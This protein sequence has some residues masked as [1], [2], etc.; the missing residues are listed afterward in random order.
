MGLI[1]PQSDCNLFSFTLQRGPQ[2]NGLEKNGVY[3]I[4]DVVNKLIKG[5]PSPSVHPHIRD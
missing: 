5:T 4:D 2:R 3:H 1:G